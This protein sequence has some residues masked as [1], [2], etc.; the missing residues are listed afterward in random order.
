MVKKM[1]EVERETFVRRPTY[2]KH[3]SPAYLRFYYA[4]KA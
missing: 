2:L 1:F 3:L 4:S